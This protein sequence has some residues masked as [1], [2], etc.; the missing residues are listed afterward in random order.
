MKKYKVNLDECT[1][2]YV[3]SMLNST[4]LE[5]KAPDISGDNYLWKLISKVIN[6]Y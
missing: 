1:A 2:V 3:I 6:I 5:F 4:K